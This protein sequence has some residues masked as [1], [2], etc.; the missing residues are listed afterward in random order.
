[1]T[2]PTSETRGAGAGS[3]FSGDK[4]AA[5]NFSQTAG[6]VE[7]RPGIIES[8]NIDPLNENSNKG[9]SE[10][11]AAP[12]CPTAP[13]TRFSRAHRQTMAG[14]MRL[15]PHCRRAQ[16]CLRTHPALLVPRR[17]SLRAR[18]SLRMAMR[19]VMKQRSRRAERLFGER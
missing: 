8:A 13:L 5:R 17:L 7:G 9:T 15:V 4:D 6:V 2:D 12:P 16:L 11:R 14:R 10:T 18:R 19:L 3:N 1:M